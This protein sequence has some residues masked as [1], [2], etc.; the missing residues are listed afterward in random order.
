MINYIPLP[1]LVMSTGSSASISAAKYWP[2]AKCL[3]LN[4]EF[5]WPAPPRHGSC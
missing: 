2:V 5:Q 1:L 3:N 4:N